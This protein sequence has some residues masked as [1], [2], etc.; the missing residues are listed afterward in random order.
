MRKRNAKLFFLFSLSLLLLGM[1]LYWQSGI[2]STFRVEDRDFS[3]DK[4][5]EITRI[6]MESLSEGKKIVLHKD[7]QER[8]RLD[9]SL[10]ANDLAVSELIMML[11]RLSVRQP[12]SIANKSQVEEMLSTA[13]VLVDVFVVAHRVQFGNFRLFPYENRFQSI[14]VGPDTPDGRSTYMRKNSSDLAF[15]VSRPGYERGISEVFTPEQRVWR[16]PVILDLEYESIHSVNVVVYGNEEESFVLKPLDEQ[17]F[18][19]FQRENSEDA[20]EFKADTARVLR[21]LSSFKDIHYERLPDEEDE[22]TRKELMFEQPFMEISV[23]SK[24]GMQTSI[25]AY[26]RL[27]PESIV[28]LAEGI[29]QDPNRFYVQVNDGEF[30]LAQYY[31]FNRI[32][33]PLSFFENKPAEPSLD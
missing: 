9:S 19:F 25:K 4:D 17:D 12:V 23:K 29:N 15:K 33:R 2:Y 31:V 1:I 14:I 30:A 20:L 22:K 16:D 24:D 8:W 10:F 21:F 18:R 13:G 26:A 11:E 32:L 7:K 28:T 6:E 3:V 5:L 27:A